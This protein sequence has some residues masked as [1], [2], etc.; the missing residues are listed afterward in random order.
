MTK[1][2]IVNWAGGRGAASEE[3]KR[4]AAEILPEISIKHHPLPKGGFFSGTYILTFRGE[5]YEA[6]GSV[7]YT[8]QPDHESVR[9]N[10]ALDLA[11]TLAA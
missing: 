6:Y 2:L 8:A 9:R 10:F 11:K 3:I 5:Q 1:K 4:M 7:P